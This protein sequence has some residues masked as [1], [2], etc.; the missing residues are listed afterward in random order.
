MFFFLIYITI[1]IC[2]LVAPYTSITIKIYIYIYINTHCRNIN[3]IQYK[4]N[5]IKIKINYVGSDD[6]V[7]WCEED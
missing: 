3:I 2:K 4:K 5:E 1:I 7:G 6:C